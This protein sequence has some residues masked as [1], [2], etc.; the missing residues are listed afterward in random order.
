[1][2]LLGTGESQPQQARIRSCVGGRGRAAPAPSR[3][4]YS[5]PLIVV[6][7]VPELMSDLAAAANSVRDHA[8]HEQSFPALLLAM[9]YV[10]V[11]EARSAPALNARAQTYSVLD[12]F[13]PI[14]GSNYSVSFA[15]FTAFPIAS[16]RRKWR[17][18]VTVDDFPP[19]PAPRAPVLHCMPSPTSRPR[20]AGPARNDR[21]PRRRADR[22]GPAGLL[23]APPTCEGA[24]PPNP[25]WLRDP[26]T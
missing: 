5:V 23:E 26:H 10:S 20:S 3:A 22:R 13:L 2:R 15:Q 16:V 25:S 14:P 8:S 7:G 21:A 18:G 11:T 12:P 24:T 19:P 6:T 9:G 4:E 17:V 1:M